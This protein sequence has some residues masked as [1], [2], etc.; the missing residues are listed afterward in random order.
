MIEFHAI[1]K[2]QKSR[3]T[4]GYIMGGDA[5]RKHHL[6]DMLDFE[7]TMWTNP[8]GI[9]QKD[10]SRTYHWNQADFIM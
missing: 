4:N 7:N 9:F 5:L 1:K 8:P 2:Y 10:L 6:D 3:L